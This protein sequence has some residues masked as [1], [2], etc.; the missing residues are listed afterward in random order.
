MKLP[1][2]LSL[3]ALSLILPA[4]ST[5]HDEPVATTTSTTE[6]TETHVH[7]PASAATTTT[8]VRSY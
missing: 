1:V 7:V 3:V 5:E 4:C 6:T 2:L 8:T